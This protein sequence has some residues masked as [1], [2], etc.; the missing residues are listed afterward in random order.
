MS[1]ILLYGAIL[2]T[3]ITAGLGYWNYSYYEVVLSEKKAALQQQEQELT[4]MNEELNGLKEK[5][6]SQTANEQEF[7][8]TLADAQQGR[9]KAESDLAEVQKQLAAKNAELDQKNKDLSAKEATIQSLMAAQKSSVPAST[10]TPTT[11]KKSSKTAAA[12]IEKKDSGTLRPEAT[13]VEPLATPAGGIS[14]K[15]AA[16]NPSWNFV[17]LNVGENNGLTKDSEMAVMR[18]GQTIGKIKITSVEPLTSIGDIIP[19]SVS[20]GSMIQVGDQVISTSI[21]MIKK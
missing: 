21:E 6:A 15:V 7:Q 20:P 3:V 16:V 9:I 2:I 13:N 1:K 14:G 11:K 12:A 19:N 18:N 10:P 4:K 17:V 5:M 8:K